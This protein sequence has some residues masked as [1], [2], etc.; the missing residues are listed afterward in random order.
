[1]LN[2]N[3][4]SSNVEVKA[5]ESPFYSALAKRRRAEFDTRTNVFSA[6]SIMEHGALSMRTLTRPTLRISIRLIVR[7]LLGNFTVLPS[8]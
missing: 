1:M 8:N 2:S 3:A 6:H 7:R 4:L 5:P